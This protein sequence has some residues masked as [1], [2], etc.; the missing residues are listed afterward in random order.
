MLRMRVLSALAVGSVVGAVLVGASAPV[1]MAAS[2]P[3]ISGNFVLTDLVYEG[4]DYSSGASLQSQSGGT[5]WSGAWDY[6]QGGD[7]PLGIAGSGLTYTGLPVEGLSTAYAG[8]RAINGSG[9]DLSRVDSGIV[10]VQLLVNLSGGFNNGA[11]N[12]RFYDT[13]ASAN[14]GFIGSNNTGNNAAILS[15]SSVDIGNSGVDINTGTTHLLVVRIDYGA[16]QTD[17]WVNP[18]VTTFDYGNPPSADATATSFAPEFDRIYLFNRSSGSFDEFRVMRLAAAPPP[19]PVRP[20]AP[21]DVVAVPGNRSMSV[22]W[23]APAKPGTWSVTNYQAVSS[24]PGGQCLTQGTTSCEMSG[25]SNGTAYTFEVRALNGAGWGPWSAPS[26]SVTPGPP[27]PP[28]PAPSIMITG[29]RGD[30]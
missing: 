19:P 16:Q 4:F 14:T 3:V 7:S 1:T 9:R 15:A 13:N 22:S 27:P 11:P 25:L 26:E 21:L 20:S 29:T 12:L 10:Y 28:P 30:V 18:D 5:G 2:W 23:S 17:L 24:P 6:A 8:V